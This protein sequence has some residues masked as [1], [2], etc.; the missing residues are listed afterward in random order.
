[1]RTQLQLLLSTIALTVLIWTYADQTGHESYETVQHVQFTTA[2]DP[3]RPI[4]LRVKEGHSESRDSARVALKLRGPR[5]AIRKLSKDINDANFELTVPIVEELRPG[6]TLQRNLFED[7]SRL[8]E[9]R[10]RGLTL[11]SVQPE[12]VELE[13]DSYTS[14]EVEVELVAGAFEKSL[15]GKPTVVPDKVT[16]RLLTSTLERI[17][18]L[19]PLRLSIENEL[20]TRTEPGNTL[21]FY[22]P[23]KSPWPGIQATFEPDRVRVTATIAKR[24]VAERITLIPLRVL[25]D[26]QDFIGKYVIEWQ[27]ETGGHFTQAIDVM[28]PVEKAGQLKGN[29]IDAYVTILDSDLPRELPGTVTTAPSSTDTWIERE[30]KFVFPPQFAQDV[31]ITGPPRTVKFRI[32]RET[33]GSASPS[34]TPAVLPLLPAPLGS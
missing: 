13:V 21:T 32:R 24:S 9:L 30:V 31:Q 34:A 29:M 14:R 19:P 28:V 25:V 11:N 2:S 26:P 17:G 33:S 4:V 16:V 5:S 23:I 3:D 20:Q 22:L 8:P 6:T 15:K 10:N 12:V 7:L 1:M 27:D 18:D